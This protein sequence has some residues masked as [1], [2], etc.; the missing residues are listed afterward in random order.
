MEQRDQLVTW[1]F[2]E[3]MG[4]EAAAKRVKEEFGVTA[5][6]T[7]VGRFYRRMADERHAAELAMAGGSVKDF[8]R[9]VRKLMGVATLK[10]C[11]HNNISDPR[12]A[13]MK[14]MVTLAK[15]MLKDEERETKEQ[16]LAL[17]LKRLLFKS[18]GEI[19]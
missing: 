9:A 11:I 4:Y 3:G 6:S 2:D 13:N 1:L 17:E 10:A 8:R 15:L 18:E 12:K 16:W 7:A 5:S 19:S 14:P